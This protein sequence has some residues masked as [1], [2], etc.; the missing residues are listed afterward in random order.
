MHY[1][2]AKLIGTVRVADQMIYAEDRCVLHI[3]AF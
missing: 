1:L 3:W 2:S